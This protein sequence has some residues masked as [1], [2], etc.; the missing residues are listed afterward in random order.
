MKKNNKKN[1]R[2]IGDKRTHNSKDIPLFW[3]SKRY[4]NENVYHA[5]ATS[6]VIAFILIA[7]ACVIASATGFIDSNNKNSYMQDRWLGFAIPGFLCIFATIICK[8]NERK[9]RKQRIYDLAASNGR[10]IEIE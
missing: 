6:C 2:V 3:N 4:F 5:I 7:A 1:N 10:T 9:I 8:I